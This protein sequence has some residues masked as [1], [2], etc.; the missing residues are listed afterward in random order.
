MNPMERLEKK[1]SE[2]IK[3]VHKIDGLKGSIRKRPRAPVNLLQSYTSDEVVNMAKEDSRVFRAELCV[4][5]PTP[6]KNS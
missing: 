1:T 3:A 6:R 4:L 5:L 2:M